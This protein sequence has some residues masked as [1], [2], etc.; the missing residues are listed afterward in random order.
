[1]LW[2]TAYAIQGGVAIAEKVR[3]SVYVDGDLFV[4]GRGA[5][6][7]FSAVLNY[8]LAALLEVSYDDPALLRKKRAHMEAS[9]KARFRDE[10]AAV[11]AEVAAKE[12]E[13]DQEERIHAAIMRVIGPI[14]GMA[15]RRLHDPYGDYIDWWE[16][17]AEIASKDAGVT[18][19][20]SDI[21]LVVKNG[22]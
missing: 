6:L 13:A 4:L 22:I 11:A 15:R 12:A 14:Q 17:L 1:M 19:E 9:I 16:N 2:H 10:K 18:I 3:T 7:N 5:G 20:A 8:A 21:R